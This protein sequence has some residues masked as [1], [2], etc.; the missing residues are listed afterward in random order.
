MKRIAALLILLAGI[1]LGYF[2]YHNE[3][4][5]AR[6]FR[7]GLDLAG[8]TLLTY[9]ADT[10]GLPPE[11][12]EAAMESLHE[13]IERRVNVFGVSE[14]IVQTERAT[15]AGGKEDRLIV[16]LPGV[17]DVDA[18]VAALGQTP[19]LEFKLESIDST[20]T[21]TFT[22][23]GLTGR[24]L[25]HAQ[26]QF[27]SSGGGGLIQQPIVALTFND[28]G[29]TLFADIT[30][31]NIGRP[32]AIFLD[33]VMISDPI[34]QSS[35]TDGK[36]VI[37]GTNDPKI[38]KELVRNLNFGALPLPI[39][40]IGADSIGA[41]LGSQITTSGVKAGMWGFLI[42]ALFMI[43]WY[44][45]PGFI[46]TIGLTLYTI[47]LL[48]LFQLIPVTLTAAGMAGFIMT[49]GIAVDANILV[50]ERIKEEMRA[51][52]EVSESIKEAFIR[53]W[54]SIRD[55]HFTAI[56]TAII[57]FY[58]TTSL[59]KGFALTLILGVAVSLL[60]SVTL[61]RVLLIAIAPKKL[62]PLTHFLFG[63]GLSK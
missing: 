2:V 7:L 58:T 22:D 41:S 30:S 27:G 15:V 59:V 28:E 54:F 3:V 51:G 62:T 47:I 42:I 52:K 34:I 60:T 20:G 31:K 23:T 48:A 11:D 29:R 6:P 10:S 50:F 57:L 14:P 19:V 45:L 1:G 26:L 35:I 43:L 21:S 8:G 18:A 13:V 53:A 36:A 16:E 12:V 9:H 38:A 44:R 55:G 49:L 61:S 5:G 37:T 24:Y 32:L 25:T 63:S 4:S 56:L 46:A 39:N 17:T 40:L 33:G